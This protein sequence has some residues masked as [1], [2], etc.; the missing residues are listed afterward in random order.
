M[1]FPRPIATFAKANWHTL[2]DHNASRWPAKGYSMFL[3]TRPT[4]RRSDL[5]LIDTHRLTQLLIST[6]HS[7]LSLKQ[8]LLHLL[9]LDFT[10]RSTQ[11]F[12]APVFLTV[13]LMF[14]SG[15]VLQELSGAKKRYERG[16]GWEQY[17]RWTERRSILVPFLPQLYAPLPTFLKRTLFLDFPIYVFDPARHADQ[18]KGA[19]AGGRGGKEQQHAG[20]DRK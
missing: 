10:P 18:R 8:C 12:S 1:S 13:L 15:L 9:C 3:T 7:R 4:N 5:R 19:R 20:E 6:S 16:Y 14:V 11:R 2:R 17:K